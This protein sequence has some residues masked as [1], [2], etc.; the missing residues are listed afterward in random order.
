MP[1]VESRNGA[2]HGRDHG[3]QPPRDPALRANV[4]SALRDT[5]GL[6]PVTHEAQQ[7]ALLNEA[8]TWADEGLQLDAENELTLLIKALVL[9]ELAGFDK[10]PK[11]KA[12][13]T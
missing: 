2:L 1:T 11:R 4:A 3:R 8:R 6:K 5:I 7:Q 9:R 13:R 12:G 10:D